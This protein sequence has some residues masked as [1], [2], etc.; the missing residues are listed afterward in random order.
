[1][2]VNKHNENIEAE[3]KKTGSKSW[4]ARL[5]RKEGGGE[6]RLIQTPK[7][8]ILSAIKQGK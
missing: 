1:M 3:V 4:C 8:A 7:Y 6:S 2:L 5:E